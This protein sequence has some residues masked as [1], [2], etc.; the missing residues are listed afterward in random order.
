MLLLVRTQCPP[1]EAF[2]E[3]CSTFPN[4]KDDDQVDQMSQALNRPRAMVSPP[5]YSPPM[6]RL[7]KRRTADGWLICW[8]RV[9]GCYMRWNWHFALQLLTPTAIR[10]NGRPLRRAVRGT[11]MVQSEHRP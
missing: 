1:Q 11:V 5:K 7:Q 8:W 10:L 9:T 3:E 2:V 6:P 4:W